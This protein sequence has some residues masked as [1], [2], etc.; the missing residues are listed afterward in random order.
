MSRLNDWDARIGKVVLTIDLF[1]VSYVVLA[2]PPPLVT[3]LV[4]AVFIILGTAAWAS[5]SSVA[6]EAEEEQTTRQQDA[7]TILKKQYARGEPSE[8]EFEY[9]VTVLLAA[10]E[11]AGSN[12]E[13]ELMAERE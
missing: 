5:I 10:D 11:I 9:R 12:S 4:V 6:S 1:F 13:I 3:G 7:L 2:G 8:E